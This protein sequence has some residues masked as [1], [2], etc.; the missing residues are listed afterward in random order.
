MHC[1]DLFF[2]HFKLSGESNEDAHDANEHRKDHPF[3]DPVCDSLEVRASEEAD[4][5]VL[6]LARLMDRA[7]ASRGVSDNDWAGLGGSLLC[8][9]TGWESGFGTDGVL[10]RKGALTSD[11]SWAATA[12]SKGEKDR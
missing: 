2:I 3:A 5:K 8:F 11:R 10:R 4:N 7:G 12:T 6:P 1:T 9:T